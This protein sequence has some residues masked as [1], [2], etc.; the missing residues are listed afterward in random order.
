MISLS[1]CCDNTKTQPEF[2]R[3]ARHSL[4]PA[5]ILADNHALLPVWDVTLH[6]PSKDG[7]GEEIVDGTFEETL[8]LGCV[9]IDGDD[10]ID[11]GHFHEVGQHASRNGTSVGFLLRL[12]RVREVGHDSYKHMSILRAAGRIMG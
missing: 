5:R 1:L 8:G 2:V 9:Q 11:A 7:L 4:C 6:P 3:Q 12:A 10:M